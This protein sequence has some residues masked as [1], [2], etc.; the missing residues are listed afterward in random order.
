MK[1]NFN[2]IRYNNFISKIATNEYKLHKFKREWR[3]AIL[4]VLVFK[5]ATNVVSIYAGYN[6]FNFILLPLINKALLTSIIAIIFLM[7]IEILTVIFL[8]KSFKFLLRTKY[9]AMIMPFVAAFIMFGISFYTSTN[10]LAM[11]RSDK[12]DQ[13]QT[14]TNKYDTQKEQIKTDYS[15][16]IQ[17]VEGFITTLKQNPAGW[18]NG[19]R[20]ILTSEQ[21]K[22]IDS[23][24]NVISLHRDKQKALT[25]AINKDM[26]KEISINKTLMTNEATKYYRIVIVIMIVQI[27]CN[28][29]LMFFYS[30]IYED[31]N[32]EAHIN[33]TVQDISEAI[34]HN[35][36]S[37]LAN[38]LQNT[39]N[40]FT[41]ALEIQNHKNEPKNFKSVNE[42]PSEIDNKKNKS[43]VVIGGFQNHN[44]TG[45]KSGYKTGYKTTQK[46]SEPSTYAS[47]F[48]K[49]ETINKKQLNYLNKHKIIVR[50][51][52]Q[53]F[54]SEKEFLSNSEIDIIKNY[55]K[56]APYKSRQLIRNVFNVMQGVGFENI[57]PDG[58]LK[59]IKKNN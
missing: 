47:G 50:T 51:I 2:N 46:T 44:K 58:S 45:F 1:I 7:F 21:T 55:S 19:K 6:Y 32:K 8:K 52:K 37:L 17:Q 29:G 5:L 13:T 4:T 11:Q 16:R 33:E 34:E 20:C 41:D 31:D 15:N 24:Y 38:K 49:N 27:L 14:I 36:F 30:R 48:K 54:Q 35:V 43:E 53:N 59:L 10:G 42:I 25:T 22:K 9:K 23:L 56:Y 3:V 18:Q 40:F 12:A 26:K 39:M 28:L 57:N